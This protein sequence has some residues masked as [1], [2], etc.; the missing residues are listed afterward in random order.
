MFGSSDDSKG[1]FGGFTRGDIYTGPNLRVQAFNE[2]DGQDAEED[3]ENE[4]PD[5]QHGKK[6]KANPSQ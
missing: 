5:V 1:E 2:R 3:Q 6:R 4:A